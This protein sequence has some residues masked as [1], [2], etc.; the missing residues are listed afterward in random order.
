MSH[1]IDIPNLSLSDK[2]AIADALYSTEYRILSQ[3]H[4]Q[5]RLEMWTLSQAF[6]IAS[7]IYLHLAI[8]EF[9][10]LSKVHQRLLTYL[11][12]LLRSVSWDEISEQQASGDVLLWTAFVAAAASGSGREGVLFLS[13]KCCRE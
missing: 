8:R 13:C 1:A 7:L 3:E 4:S 5:T 9:P 2:K 12:V 10:S 6:R 11:L